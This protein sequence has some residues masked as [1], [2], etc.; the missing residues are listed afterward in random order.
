MAVLNV[1]K[2]GFKVDNGCGL[3]VEGAG[4]C[5]KGGGSWRLGCGGADREAAGLG[6]A[7]RPEEE[8]GGQALVVRERRGRAGLVGRGVGWWAGQL[9]PADRPRPK[10]WAGRLGWKRK[11]KRK[12]IKN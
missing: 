8:E 5:T 4:S 1:F 7:A 9:G 10:E 6:L 11:L 12:S 2:L 3:M